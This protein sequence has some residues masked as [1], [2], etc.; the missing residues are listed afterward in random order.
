MAHPPSAI[1]GEGFSGFRQDTRAKHFRSAVAGRVCAVSAD[2]I[3]EPIGKKRRR[4]ITLLMTIC[5]KLVFR[6]GPKA[7]KRI[8]RIRNERR[9]VP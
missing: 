8:I 6:N 1:F 9:V 2:R 4:I 3:G 7:V 5:E